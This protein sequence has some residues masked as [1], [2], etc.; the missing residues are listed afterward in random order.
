MS[1]AILFAVVLAGCGQPLTPAEMH[2][3]PQKG[4]LAR[5]R[6]VLRAR[7][8]AMFQ[9]REGATCREV[10]NLLGFPTAMCFGFL[11]AR[12]DVY[13]K[14]GF[15]VSYGDKQQVVNGHQEEGPLVKGTRLLSMP[16]LL[17][18]LFPAWSGAGENR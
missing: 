14:L 18:D 16:D 11:N 5:A 17:P 6:W 9:V 4:T 10:M 1:A 3:P 7:S 12:H 2:S 15:V 13:D 8:T